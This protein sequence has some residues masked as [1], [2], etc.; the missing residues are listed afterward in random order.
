MTNLFTPES[1]RGHQIFYGDKYDYSLVKYTDSKIKV[2]IICKKHGEFKQMPAMHLQGQGCPNCVNS[3]GENEIFYYD[4]VEATVIAA[5]IN[6]IIS[7]L[8]I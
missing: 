6:K 2:N 3:M 7:K 8:D 5:Q 1:C 4:K